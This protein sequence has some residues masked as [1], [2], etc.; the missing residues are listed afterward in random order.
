MADSSITKKALANS[1]KEL[2]TEKPFL[3]ISISDICNGCQMNRKSF[4]Y[5][6]K[7]KY[8]LVNWIFDTECKEIAEKN[9]M[10]EKWAFINAFFKYFY[11]NRSFY[12]KCLEIEGQNSLSEHF[13]ELLVPAIKKRLQEIIGDEHLTDFQ[14]YFLTD[15]VC[16][17]I[18]RWILDKDCMTSEEFLKQ[19]QIC[20]MALA[21]HTRESSEE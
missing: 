16:C 8:D 18:K 19:M 14:T 12:R 21:N 1:L 15:A 20:V 9:Q 4:Y 7:D 13:Q 6:F 11:D 17:A 5:H 2:M 10:L 3:K